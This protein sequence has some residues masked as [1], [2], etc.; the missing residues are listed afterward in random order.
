MC[1]A[2]GYEYEDMAAERLNGRA[3]RMSAIQSKPT[4]FR[5]L[6]HAIPPGNTIMILVL[7][8][9]LEEFIVRK[10]RTQH[11]IHMILQSKHLYDAFIDS[12]FLEQRSIY[13]L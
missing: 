10:S 4:Y 3:E 11:K 13:A 2:D 1:A 8:L 5:E 12:T 9:I 6:S 7:I